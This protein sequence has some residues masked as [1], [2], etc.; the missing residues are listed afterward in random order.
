MTVVE[1][2]VREV[3]NS[4]NQQPRP[5]QPKETIQLLPPPVATAVLAAA[6]VSWYCL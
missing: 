3:E 6:A 1:Q 4:G 2:Y 5:L